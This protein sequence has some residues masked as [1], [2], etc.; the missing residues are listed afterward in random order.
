[1]KRK[2]TIKN[3][4]DKIDIIVDK[5]KLICGDD[6]ESRDKIKKVL[7]N[8]F[9]KIGISDFAEDKHIS[10]V[11]F[12]DEPININDFI[13]FCVD[14]NYDLIQD[15]K[16]GSKS[17]ALEYVNSL[18]DD[19]EY[20]DEYQTINNLLVNLLEE[21]IENAEYYIRSNIECMLTKKLLVKLIELSFLNDDTTINNYDLTLEERIMVQLNMIKQ[22]SL[23]TKKNVLLLI[24]CPIVSKTIIDKLKEFD[25]LSL[26]IFDKIVEDAYD[27]ILILDKVRIDVSDEDALYELCFN[28]KTAYYTIE[29]MKN[30][31][32]DNY[33]K[34]RFI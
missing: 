25:V 13:F 19:I 2:I 3:L 5:V 29:E 24:E 15:T 34:P 27:D 33:V 12:D 18:F 4:N 10:E 14:A 8:K 31:M 20:L 17:L 21:R 30:K 32:I 28:D 11:L 1:M 26:V 22:I 7:I 9:N 23:T 6:F 16:L